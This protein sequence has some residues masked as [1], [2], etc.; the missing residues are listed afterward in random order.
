MEYGLIS[1][2]LSLQQ[3]LKCISIPLSDREQTH[4]A[5]YYWLPF[6]DHKACFYLTFNIHCTYSASNVYSSTA[7]ASLEQERECLV[8]EQW[9]PS[10]DFWASILLA[11]VT[12]DFLVRGGGA[13]GHGRMLDS[14]PKPSTHSWHVSPP[15]MTQHVSR[16]CQ[17]SLCGGKELVQI[18]GAKV[19]TL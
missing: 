8:F 14:V 2:W 19:A 17:M 13:L 5:Y 18:Y 16:H 15:M 6:C 9:P 11:F 4:D 3:V 7:D 10:Q 1:M 12:R